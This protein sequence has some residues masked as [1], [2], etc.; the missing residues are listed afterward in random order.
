MQPFLSWCSYVYYFERL[1]A[2]QNNTD[3]LCNKTCFKSHVSVQPNPPVIQNVPSGAATIQGTE[4]VNLT[5]ICISTGGYPQQTLEWYNGS[6]TDVNRLAGTTTAVSA[7][8]FNVTS[9]YKFA[10]RNTDDGVTFICRSLYSGEPS[11]EDNT[12]VTLE[13]SCKY[14]YM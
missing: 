9:T 10:P 11:M 4:G 3:I 2:G 1:Q 13:L 12:N 8:Q 14:M 7:E 5:L 6:V